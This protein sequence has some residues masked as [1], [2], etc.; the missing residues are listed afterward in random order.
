[1]AETQPRT[2][3]ALSALRAEHHPDHTAIICEGRHIS[4][5]RL[6]QE[7]NRTANALLRAGLRPGSRVAY[8][9]RESEHYYE[10]AM[11]CA[12]S[13]VVLVPANWRLTAGEVEH[14]LRDSCAELIF[15]EREFRRLVTGLHSGLPQLRTV[16][17]MDTA[18]E[19]SAGFTAWKADSPHSDPGLEVRPGD[20]VAQ[21]YTSGTTGLPKGVVVSNLSFFITADAVT[22]HGV[23]W[24]D[25]QPG[26]VSLVAM[27]GFHLSGLSWFMQG[28]NG[29]ATNVVMRMFVSEEA[30]RLIR[31]LGVTVTFLAP[32]MLQMLLDEPQASSRNFGTLRKI[33]YGGAPITEHL[34]LRCMELL[35]C[36]LVQLYASTETGAFV[37]GLPAQEHVPGNPRLRAA[38]RVFPNAEVKI[39]D[40]AGEALPE[41]DIGEVW[42]RSPARML[43]Y[44]RQPEATAKTLVD[45]WIRMGDAGYFQDGYLYL[46]DRIKDMIIVA[47][48]NIYPAEVEAVLAAHPAVAEAAVIAVPDDRWGEAVQACVVPR[49]GQSLTA[50]ELARF[51]RGRIADFKAPTRYEFVTEL[52][53]NPN[54]KILRR[55]LREKFWQHLETRIH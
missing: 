14:I 51:M 44:W 11:A 22:E 25:F 15:V 32:A 38:G 3:A 13:G 50:R 12:K 31:Q 54:G 40:E 26:D 55:A 35:G 18:Q 4:Y 47:G 43:E 9:G 10:I 8:L 37:V 30:L 29:G 23:T 41:G 48:E 27:P 52:P 28:L 19:R 24:V 39:A 46:C 33:V 49:P 16:V 6:H 20:A 36:E 5:G 2:L 53:R 45:G 17:E 1:M 21:I 34:L 7:S 42:V